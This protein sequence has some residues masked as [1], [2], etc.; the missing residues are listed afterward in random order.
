MRQ[1]VDHLLITCPICRFLG[2]VHSRLELP[3]WRFDVHKPGDAICPVCWDAS[4][5]TLPASMPDRGRT[6]ATLLA[7]RAGGEGEA[8]DRTRRPDRASDPQPLAFRRRARI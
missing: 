8:R 5:D 4:T 3:G 6:P 1:R 7:F 2:L